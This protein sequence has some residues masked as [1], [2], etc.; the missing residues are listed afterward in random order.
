M[1]T[2]PEMRQFLTD[3]GFIV[4]QRDSRLNRKYPGLFMACEPFEESE[5]PTDDGSNGPWCIVG[6]DLDELIAEAYAF[7]KSID[8]GEG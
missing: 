7:A 8:Y 2:I 3:C 1:A 5:V 4:G 6:D